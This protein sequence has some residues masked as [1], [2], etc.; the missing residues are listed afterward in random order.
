MEYHGGMNFGHFMLFFEKI[1]NKAMLIDEE[2]ASKFT[3]TD[4]IDLNSELQRNFLE[5]YAPEFSGSYYRP[6]DMQ[7]FCVDE[8][9]PEEKNEFIGIELPGIYNQRFKLD[10]RPAF[11]I[12]SGKRNSLYISPYGY[13]Y[14]ND[15]SDKSWRMASS[16]TF[17]RSVNKYGV[18][19][20]DKPIVVLQDQFDGGNFAHFIYDYIPRLISFCYR[21]ERIAKSA[22]FVCGGVRS[23]LHDII[24]NS[25]S[26]ACDLDISQFFFPKNREIWNTSSS[27]F[28]FSDQREAITHPLHMCRPET[29][30]VVRASVDISLPTSELPRR[31][32][33][34][35]QDAA[36]RRISNEDEFVPQLQRLGYTKVL[37]SALTAP[38][39][40]ELLAN[41]THVV[42]PHGMGLTPI[43]FSKRPCRLIELFSPMI[44][45]D[46]YAFISKS[47]GIRYEY[48]VGS[49]GAVISDSDYQIN[50]Q[51]L[52]DRVA[53]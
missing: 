40:I 29:V 20:L 25:V 14:F 21:N 2:T 8:V 6:G 16:R 51:E 32:Y 19:F 11:R 5:K 52:L 50:V 1:K 37:M 24:L 33:I 49:R 41:A 28:F 48:I 23:S 43:L 53:S 15:L 42:A 44:G 3:Q 26:A 4:I 9:F 27:V 46:A 38:Q 12:Y 39:Q 17:S 47:I 22:V 7:D 34:S 35:R 36:M 10:R 45:S 18:V 30:R 31:I 13:Q